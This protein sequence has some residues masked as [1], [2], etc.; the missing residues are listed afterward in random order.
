M[1]HLRSSPR[2]TLHSKAL[3][4]QELTP[5]KS[6]LCQ[7]VLRLTAPSQSHSDQ[8]LNNTA[9]QTPITVKRI[10][11]QCKHNYLEHWKEET[12]SQSRLECYLAL[13]REYELA[14]YLSTVRDRKQRQILTKH[15]LSDH[16]LAT[17]RHNRSWQPKENRICGHCTTG[18]TETEMHFLLK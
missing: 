3:Q 11:T 14:E 12:R 6:P 10:I 16:T 17:G 15:R 2:D 8:S 1:N 5:E 18:E 4:S 13:K 7:L 9:L